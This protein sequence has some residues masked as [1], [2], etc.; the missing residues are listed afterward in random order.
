M[1]STGPLLAYILLVTLVSSIIATAVIPSFMGLSF[2]ANEDIAVETDDLNYDQGDSVVITGTVQ[3]Y[4]PDDDDDTVKVR[5]YD[6]TG[7]QIDSQTV[8]VD[9]D[10]DFEA[11]EVVLEDDANEG[12]YKVLVTHTGDEDSTIFFKVEDDEDDR[13]DLDNINDEYDPGDKITISGTVQDSTLDEDSVE[14]T[15]Y[16]A[17]G[18]DITTK[19]ADLESNDDFSTSYTLS[20]SA[21]PGVYSIKLSYDNDDVWVVF[22]VTGDSGGSSSGSITIDTDKSSYEAG[23]TITITGQVDALA[24]GKKVTIVIRDA[25]DDVVD[26][27]EPTPSSSTKKFSAQIDLPEDAVTGTYK[28]TATYNGDD[29]DTTFTVGTT[30]S[31]GGS[32]TSLTAKLNKSSYL[33]GDSITITGTVPKILVDEQV[34]IVIFTPQSIFVSAVYIDPDDDKTFSA[35]IKL[36]SDLKVASGYKVEVSYGTQYETSL[37]FSITGVGS[38]SSSGSL[39]V[40]TD[41]TSYDPGA[42]IKVSGKVPADQLSEGQNVLIQVKNPNGDVYRYDQVTPSSDGSYTYDLV[43]GGN[44][45]MAGKYD[46]TVTYK[47]QTSKT[48]FNLG[49]SAT[50]F[51]LKFE[52]KTYQIEYGM[53]GGAVKSMFIEKDNKKLVITVDATEDGQ[54]TLTLPREI[55]DAR[56]GSDGRSGSDAKFVI[57][58]EGSTGPTDD[59]NISE[60][61]TNGNTRTV[62]IDYKA[63][64]NRIEISGT[65]VVPEFGAISAIVLAIA[66]VGIIMATARFGNKFSLMRQ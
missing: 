2:A 65:S 6:P 64:T 37:T 15:I 35:V 54:L 52:D 24:S 10:G 14:V 16:G 21:D 13:I 20:S 12:R 28:V 41:K 63:G 22:Q 59:V 3:D 30:T 46:V 1:K 18:D 45:G 36:K 17:D 31:G 4:D 29:T 58:A 27:A 57:A 62:V 48:T 19:N 23:D 38:G 26:F 34:N 60:S 61:T 44:L 40:Q 25:D 50:T 43:V 9:D 53:S 55:I 7:S 39:S 56:T 66:I 51:P 5:V 11:N 47:Q 49:S 8:D 33:A 32:S 42:K